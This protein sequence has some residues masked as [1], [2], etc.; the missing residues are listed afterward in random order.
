MLPGTATLAGFK[1]V[2]SACRGQH[3]PLPTSTDTTNYTASFKYLF[4]GEYSLDFAKRSA[5]NAF[6]TAPPPRPSP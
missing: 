2:L 6:V 4:P 1:A 5:V 3:H